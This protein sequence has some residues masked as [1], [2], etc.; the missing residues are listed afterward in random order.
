MVT[1]RGTK[2]LPAGAQERRWLGGFHRALR[3][4]VDA[5]SRFLPE[6]LI[7]LWLTRQVTTE[8]LPGLLHGIESTLKQS[9]Y[10]PM[11]RSTLMTALAVRSFARC[12]CCLG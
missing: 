8:A 7:E 4:E 2:S 12:S 9:D 6:S 11:L 3:S 10:K 5:V 1:M